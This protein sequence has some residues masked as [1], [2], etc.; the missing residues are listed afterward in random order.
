MQFMNFISFGIT[1]L[2]AAACIGVGFLSFVNNGLS[3]KSIWYAIAMISCA[4]WSFLMIA[5]PMDTYDKYV[6]ALRFITVAA[7]VAMLSTA[8]MAMSFL[9][10]SMKQFV[11]VFIVMAIPAVIMCVVALT[12]PSR[13]MLLDLY[14]VGDQ[15]YLDANIN[16]LLLAVMQYMY[17]IPIMSALAKAHRQATTEIGKKL[18]KRVLIGWI[19]GFC[20]PLIFNVI[21]AG[22]HELHFFGPIGLLIACIMSYGMFSK[23]ADDDL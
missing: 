3:R 22:I 17:I 14:W 23:H 4:I 10:L 5:I 12:I 20:F 8:M 11:L 15:M 7:T 6:I 21:L 9:K 2:A 1:G 16:Y 19:F 13:F 18:T